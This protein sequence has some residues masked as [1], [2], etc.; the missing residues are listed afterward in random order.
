M[1]KPRL[2]GEVGSLLTGPQELRQAD[3]AM[4]VGARQ[5]L[6]EAEQQ[7]ARAA[8]RPEDDA[9]H[10]GG[11]LDPLGLHQARNDG[12]LD[13]RGFARAAGAGEKEKRRALMRLRSQLLDGLA[14]EGV[15]PMKNG[16]ML[17]FVRLEATEGRASPQRR[18]RRGVGVH[19]RDAPLDQLA[20]GLLEAGG[21]FIQGRIGVEA[22]EK[23][24]AVGEMP[25]P[26]AAEGVELRQT[27]RAGSGVTGVDGRRR[28]IAKGENVGRPPLAR[29]FQRVLV[30][31]FGSGDGSTSVHPA[32]FAQGRA[33][34][35][36]R[37]EPRPD[38]QDDDVASAR[39]VDRILEM[40]RGE[41]RL[42]FPAIGLEREEPVV[43]GA[44]LVDD[45]LR[46]QPLLRHV[47]RRGNEELQAPHIPSCSTSRPSDRR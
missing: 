23:G 25:L 12:G 15:A 46:P 39:R 16:R 24:A 45:E 22:G 2:R 3:A 41:H 8:G 34:R 7:I 13:Q 1:M 14:D 38:D 29:R 32:I 5:R 27:L 43:I 4:F 9:A 28:E 10:E 26:E 19:R 20:Q 11:A 6:R 42:V 44:E 33:L 18:R 40:T 30:F 37:A 35:Q 21:E 17:E 36:R 47:A 31:P